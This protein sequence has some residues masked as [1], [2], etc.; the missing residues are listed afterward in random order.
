[1][2]TLPAPLLAAINHL[3][4]QATWAREKLA[5]FTGHSARITLPPFEAAFLIGED[6]YISAPILADA[7][8]AE[9]EV[10]ISLPAA[11]PLLAL[12]GKDAVMRAARIEGS[13]EFA[14][15]LGFVIRNLR[16]DAEEDLSKVVGD[17]A[18]HR[19]VGGTREFAAWQQQAAQNLAENLAE[20]FTEEQPLIARRTDIADFS[21]DIDRL[22]DDVARLEKRVQRLA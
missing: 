3:L 18:A 21:A 2:Q 17:I 7:A 1:M 11:T 12:Q 9:P 5:P 22:R 10:S 15:A 13:A 8:E 20:Y 14:E 4:G 16:W 19:I 6:G